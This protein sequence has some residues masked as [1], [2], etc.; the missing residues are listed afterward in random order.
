MSGAE[1]AQQDI[2]AVNLACAVGLPG[3]EG[4]DIA[5]CLDR[6]DQW[7]D[8][9]R[10]ATHKAI[11][12]KPKFPEYRDWS[13]ARYRALMVQ[14]CLQNHLGVKYNHAQ[15]EREYDGSDSRDLF[16]HAVLTTS[17]LAMCTTAPMIFAAIGRRLGYPIKLVKTKQHIFCRWDDSTGEQFNIEATSPGF[18]THSDEYYRAWPFPWTVFEER[19]GCWLRSLT[20]REELALFLDL[21]GTCFFDNLESQQA[22]D[23]FSAACSLDKS[24]PEIELRWA[25]VTFLQPTIQRL[26]QQ[27]SSDSSQPLVVTFPK[28]R[29]TWEK[30]CCS[31]SKNWLDRIIR[32][33][34]TRS[35]DIL[36]EFVH[37]EI[38]T[39]M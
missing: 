9:A 15:M 29:Q 33:R 7:T 5:L 8:H 14:I 20:P 28:P 10:L 6:L 13:D 19:S 11:E 37:T 34:R 18:Y 23:C 17:H 21:R 22:A 27:D 36:R 26:R 12:N 38:A 16:I 2:A 30:V 25:M 32:S 3:S 24:D 39:A 4:L 31:A 1:F 35:N